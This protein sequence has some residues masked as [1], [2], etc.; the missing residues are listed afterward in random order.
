[1]RRL[2]KKHKTKAHHKLLA[3]MPNEYRP[4]VWQK[5]N[6]PYKEYQ[7]PSRFRD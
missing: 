5:G 3:S 6:S 1:M 7:T 4:D 2:L